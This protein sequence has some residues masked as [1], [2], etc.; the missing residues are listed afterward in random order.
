MSS[1][2]LE[3][4][5]LICNINELYQK[6]YLEDVFR[7]VYVEE[8]LGCRTDRKPKETNNVNIWVASFNTGPCIILKRVNYI[9]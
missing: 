4:L 3:L 2:K 6:R 1:I 7:T 5:I 8:S 9:L